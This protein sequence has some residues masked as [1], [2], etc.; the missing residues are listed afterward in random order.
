[1]E[2]AGQRHPP[3]APLLAHGVPNERFFENHRKSLRLNKTSCELAGPR[4]EILIESMRAAS[5]TAAFRRA[6]L[7]HPVVLQWLQKKALNGGK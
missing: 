4:T 2:G 1:M 5:L 7:L 6:I 3:L